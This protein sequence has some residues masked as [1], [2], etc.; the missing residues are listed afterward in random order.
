MAIT[1]AQAYHIITASKQLVVDYNGSKEIGNVCFDNDKYRND[2]IV[3]GA[4]H[5]KWQ[6]TLDDYSAKANTNPI[7]AQAI[8]VLKTKEPQPPTKVFSWKDC[9]FDVVNA[10]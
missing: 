5:A 9:S 10:L 6:T 3:F 1:L 2:M 7:Y 4:A 8:E